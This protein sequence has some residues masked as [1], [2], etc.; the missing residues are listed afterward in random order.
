MRRRSTRSSEAATTPS[1][2][3]A[4]KSLG[5]K[6]PAPSDAHACSSQRRKENPHGDKAAQF[7]SNART[8]RFL[9]RR[10]KVSSASASEAPSTCSAMEPRGRAMQV[11]SSRTVI[12]AHQY[13]ARP[14]DASNVESSSDDSYCSRRSPCCWC[15]LCRSPWVWRCLGDSSPPPAGR[16][17]CTLPAPSP[18][19]STTI[20][21]PWSIAT[22]YCCRR[23]HAPRCSTLRSY[24]FGLV[25]R[26]DHL[27]RSGRT[28]IP[29][30]QKPTAGRLQQSHVFQVA[31]QCL[32][33]QEVYGVRP[34]YGV[35]VL[36]G[37]RRQSVAFTP[38]LERR[39]LA[40]MD[41]MRDFLET[42]RE[43]GRRW[44]DHKCL[45][46]GYHTRAGS[47]PGRPTTQAAAAPS[48]A[49]KPAPTRYSAPP[50]AFRCASTPVVGLAWERPAAR[51]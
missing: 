1:L 42:G 43:P 25:G 35:V 44:V 8:V 50:V 3:S 34:S 12:L 4:R 40:T 5:G 11:S 48:P 24:R 30:E 39:L 37:G 22:D 28:L 6:D 32:L 23:P 49:R 16:G 45:A 20:Y 26:P 19:V 51:L 10:G 47:R 38:E 33:V 27:L 17:R 7:C 13:I 29:V 15:L 41:E 2:A 21:V 14:T 9:F 36:A 46:G 31:A 18:V